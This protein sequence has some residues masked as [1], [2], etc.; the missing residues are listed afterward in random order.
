[1]QVVTPVVYLPNQV[2]DSLKIP[3]TDL[4]SVNCAI[5]SNERRLLSKISDGKLLGMF[6]DPWS[7]DCAIIID[8]DERL[9][10]KISDGKLY[11]CSM[12]CG[13][14]SGEHKM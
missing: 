3:F 4:W 1:M 5:D 2:M 11:T 9:H 12:I 13:V 7:V 8:S 10:S 6:Y 14:R